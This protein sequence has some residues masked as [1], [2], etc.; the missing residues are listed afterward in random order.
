MAG[1]EDQ[2]QEEE[3]AVGRLAAVGLPQVVKTR[4]SLETSEQ[5]PIRSSM[6]RVVGEQMAV[7]GEQMPL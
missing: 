3:V 4:R 1:V 2:Q 6:L 5:E 7:V